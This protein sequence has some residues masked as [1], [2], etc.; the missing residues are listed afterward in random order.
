MTPAIDLTLPVCILD[1]AQNSGKRL[2][3][4]FLELLLNA[5]GDAETRIEL[6]TYQTRKKL[7]SN[8]QHFHFLE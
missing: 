8:I 7:F 3:L 6:I 1:S 2:P 4:T 5:C